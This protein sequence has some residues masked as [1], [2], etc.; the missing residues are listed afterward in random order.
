FWHKQIY[1]YQMWLDGLYMGEPFY[2]E[3]SAVFGEDNWTDIA[4]QFV[5]M[6]THA[7]DPKTG[8]LY[9]GWDESKEQQ[10]ANKETGCSPNFWGRAMGWYGMAMVDVL[11]QFP[12]NHPGR[13][14]LIQILNRF[15]KAITAVQDPA[16]GLWYD[17][18]DMPKREKNYKE[19]SAS[20]MFVYALAKAVR[21]GYIPASYSGIAK[22]AYDGIIKEFIEIDASGQTNLKGTV[23]VSGLGGRPYRD[24]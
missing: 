5:W 15:A 19:A 12:A 23:S 7:R 3:Y 13:D 18:L 22:K 16:S 10:W 9:H 6:E 2:A 17:I 11:D 21:K 24:G 20:C 1:P 14:S 8:L 4:N